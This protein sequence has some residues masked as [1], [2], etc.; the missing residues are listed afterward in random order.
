M[1]TLEGGGLATDTI[2]DVLRIDKHA[3]IGSDYLARMSP[4][5]LTPVPWALVG[6]NSECPERIAEVFRSSGGS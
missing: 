5:R 2:T 4:D 1:E 6:W 3:R